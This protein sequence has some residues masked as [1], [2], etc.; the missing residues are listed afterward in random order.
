MR[1]LVLAVAILSL[2]CRFT[3]RSPQDESKQ[4]PPIQATSKGL[5]MNNKTPWKGFAEKPDSVALSLSIKD[6][7]AAMLVLSGRMQLDYYRPETFTVTYA[8]NSK[9]S[10]SITDSILWGD[11]Q[12]LAYIR[13]DDINFDG[14]ADLLL[15]NNAGATGNFWY[16]VYTYNPKKGYT[17]NKTFSEIS[18]LK[19]DTPKKQIISY[20]HFSGCEETVIYYAMAENRPKP[21]KVF[22]NRLEKN[23]CV[24]YQ[25]D[26]V[27]GRWVTKKQGEWDVSL[28][29]SL[30][31]KP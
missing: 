27:A 17:Y 29:D 15:F 13:V 6:S 1:C 31:N 3:A 25:K 10:F 18:A 9:Q 30:Y 8:D 16:N 5:E 4:M 23:S 14:F 20:Y 21:V 22:F 7:A 28:Y 11:G 26:F 12:R 19:V 24:T 2:S